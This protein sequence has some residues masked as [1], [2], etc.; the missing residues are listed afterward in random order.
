MEINFFAHLQTN[1]FSYVP[2]NFSDLTNDTTE[3]RLMT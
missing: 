2:I 3:C 1:V